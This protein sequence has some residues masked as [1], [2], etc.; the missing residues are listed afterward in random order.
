MYTS[1]RQG[2]DSTIISKMAGGFALAAIPVVV[3]LLTDRLYFALVG[4]GVFGP[5]YALAALISIGDHK[6]EWE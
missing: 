4:L 2:L 6:N 3:W 1:M 5:Y